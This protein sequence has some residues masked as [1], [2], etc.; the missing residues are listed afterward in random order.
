[1]QTTKGL[2]NTRLLHCHFLFHLNTFIQPQ[3]DES[4]SS[5][6]EVIVLWQWRC[7]WLV[8]C[9]KIKTVLGLGWSINHHSFYHNCNYDQTLASSR[10][11]Y[12]FDHKICHLKSLCSAGDVWN[13]VPAMHYPWKEKKKTV[14]HGY[15]IF[16]PQIVLVYLMTFEEGRPASL[17]LIFFVNLNMCHVK[18]PCLHCY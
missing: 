4:V 13:V 16:L 17:T 1:M 12:C 9:L 6:G 2:L 10:Q 14:W 3:T 11:T 15:I 8:F 5:D 7:Y 18:R